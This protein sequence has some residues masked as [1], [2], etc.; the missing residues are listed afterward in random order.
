MR[1][2]KRGRK[3]FEA[4]DAVLCS[5]LQIRRHEGVVTTLLQRFVNLFENFDEL[6]AGAA[7]GV[8]NVDV[9]VG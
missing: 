6:G 1:H 9:F 2:N 8:Q 5:F 4:K 3:D 7:A